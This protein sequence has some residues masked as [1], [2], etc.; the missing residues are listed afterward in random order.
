MTICYG[1][2]IFMFDGNMREI[3][4]LMVTAIVTI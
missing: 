4:D 1:R 2:F 3:W